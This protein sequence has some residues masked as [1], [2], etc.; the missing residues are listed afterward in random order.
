[1]LAVNGGKGEKSCFTPDGGEKRGPRTR[2]TSWGGGG[3]GERPDQ[4]R[5]VPVT[6][7]KFNDGMIL[8]EKKQT[9][10]VPE[11]GGNE[12]SVL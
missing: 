8:S 11:R 3:G 12:S 9:T 4:E 5:Q 10:V 6:G 7:D 1:V 2:K